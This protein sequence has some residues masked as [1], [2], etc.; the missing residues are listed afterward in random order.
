M[1]A[2]PP[3]LATGEKPGSWFYPECSLALRI[4]PLSRNQTT[5]AQ[6][7]D[8]FFF[9]ISSSSV[10][11]EFIDI[12]ANAEQLINNFF[13]PGQ[14]LNLNTQVKE[15]LP[16]LLKPEAHCRLV[17][18]RRVST[19]SQGRCSDAV[20]SAGSSAAVKGCCPLLP[21]LP[22]GGFPFHLQNEGHRRPCRRW[23]GMPPA[24]ATLL[25]G[26]AVAAGSV[27]LGMSLLWG[28]RGHFALSQA[29][30]QGLTPC[31]TG[32][33]LGEL[34]KH[35]FGFSFCWQP[36]HPPASA[37]SQ[38]KVLGGPRAVPK[39]RGGRSQGRRMGAG[40]GWDRK[41]PGAGRRALVPGQ[42]RE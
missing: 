8:F 3:H 36:S 42:T 6:V 20:G 31:M 25:P 11:F 29:G 15:Q 18:Q 26:K 21:S 9:L 5:A 33:V 34:L 23:N 35:I 28:S 4:A 30:S 1:Q 13:F 19:G 39:R 14:G 22:P 40:M 32:G 7:E 2:S 16:Y 12:F 41:L 37:V 17:S 38:S 27:A 10:V 24:A